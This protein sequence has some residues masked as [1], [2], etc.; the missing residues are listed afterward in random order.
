M[1]IPSGTKQLQQA[2]LGGLGNRDFG[3][4]IKLNKTAQVLVDMAEYVITQAQ[5]NL[6]KSGS[7]TSGQLADSMTA[8]DIEINGSKMSID[9]EI[10]DRYDFL[11]SGVKGV[12]SG[13][14]KY[15]FKTKRPS[16]GMKNSIKSWLK[17]RGRRALKYKA[18]SKT[19][20]KDK[21]IAK[22]RSEA[23]TQEGLAWAVATSIKKK[24]IK[25]TKFFTN[26]VKATERKFKKEI[27]AGFKLDIIDNI[28]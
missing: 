23:D 13:T 17:T 22:M 5:K 3:D 4:D 2:R 10:L 26:A 7:V 12:E 21:R 25:A 19:E 27:A 20:R 16:I 28:K 24:G 14:G 9:V 1:P 8:R 18:I 6:D 11:N 15:S